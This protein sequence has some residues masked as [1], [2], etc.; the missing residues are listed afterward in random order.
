VNGASRRRWHRSLMDNV[1]TDRNLLSDQEAD[2]NVAKQSARGTAAKTGIALILF[3]GVLWFSLFA[4]PFLPLTIGQ[5][6]AL[7]AADFAGVQIAWWVGAALAGPAL[8]A[9]LESRFRKRKPTDES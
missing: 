9:K 7:A 2:R 1:M 6:T 3:S 4:I 8:V 5:K